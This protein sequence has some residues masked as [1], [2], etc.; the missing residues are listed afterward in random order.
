[1]WLF[2]HV[3][4]KSFFSGISAVCFFI[5]ACKFGVAKQRVLTAT[6]KFDYFSHY[7]LGHGA[8]KW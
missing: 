7:F 4:K 8:I 3:L 1:M 2:L 6:G 5:Y